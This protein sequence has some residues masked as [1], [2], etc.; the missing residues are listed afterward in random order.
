MSNSYKQCYRRNAVLKHAHA[1]QSSSLDSRRSSASRSIDCDLN[2]LQSK[3]NDYKK[4]QCSSTLSVYSSNGS[5]ATSAHRRSLPGSEEGDMVHSAPDIR[6]LFT[7]DQD[8]TIKAAYPKREHTDQDPTIK[9]A[10]PRREHSPRL[11][12]YSASG[13]DKVFK[14]LRLR[15][16][17]GRF[18]P[19]PPVERRRNSSSPTEDKRRALIT[20]VDDRRHSTTP[21]YRRLMQTSNLLRRRSASPDRL[22]NWCPDSG[23]NCRL[24][25]STISLQ[26]A[27]PTDIPVGKISRQSSTEEENKQRS[28]LRA[29][30]PSIN[31]KE[32]VSQRALRPI[33]SANLSRQR[34]KSLELGINTIEDITNFF[35]NLKVVRRGS[36]AT[37]LQDTKLQDK[38]RLSLPERNQNLLPELVV[39]CPQE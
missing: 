17:A 24:S 11:R 22:D 2:K 25:N 5:L 31:R 15:Q 39:T 35:D 13:D 26:S 7:P 4:R 21:D 29:T 6:L 34:S 1:R 20:G 33:K 32:Q 14:D 38:K 10:Y 37:K 9:A 28:P 23:I 8:P 16:L 3:L 19:I 27:S 18:S 36:K 12:T 30:T